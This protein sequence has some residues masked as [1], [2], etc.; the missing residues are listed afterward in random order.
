M[1]SS[2]SKLYRLPEELRV[3]LKKPWGQLIPNAEISKQRLLEAVSVA[4]LIV[5]VGDATSEN[6][7]RLTIQPDIYVVD[8][9]EKRSARQPPTL[10]A[11]SEVRVKN[12]AGYISGEA[13]EGVLKAI[14]LEKP[15]RIL[16]EG[17]E[18]LLALIFFAAYPDGT[19]LFYGQPNE[20]IVA[21]RVELY[22]EKAALIL[23]QMG[24]PNLPSR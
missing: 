7:S 18:D 17:E 2:K 14:K 8:S 11:K 12:P 20:G 5:A 10:E 23:R 16:V 1:N 21:A 6:L 9:K 4:K 24:V 19:A 3:E 15:V 22:R 13:I